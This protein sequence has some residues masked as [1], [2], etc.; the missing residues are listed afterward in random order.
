L[1]DIAD[2]DAAHAALRHW[3]GLQDA[4]A[5]SI[6]LSE[7]HCFRID[8]QD[9]NRFV[10]RLH[11]PGYQSR[12]TI[13]S[14]L[15]WL[16][17]IRAETPIPVPQ[18]VPAID[19]AAIVEA[20][21]DRFAALFAFE[22]GLEPRPEEALV[23][24]FAI[25]GRYAALAHR[26]AVAWPHPSGFV[27]PTWNAAAILDANGPWGDWRAAPGV[28]GDTAAALTA[29]DRRLRAR[30]AAYG[31]G[32][33][34]FG[35]IHADMRLANLLVDG[36]RVVL[37][38]FDDCGFGWFVYDLAA[39][40]SF[41]ETSPQVPALVAAWLAAYRAVRPLSDED[42]AMV[43]VMILFRRMALLAWIGS[44][45]ETGLAAAHRGRFAVDTVDLARRLGV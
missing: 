14:E 30:L 4:A 8:A 36:P 19:G 5:T 1:N 18:P 28:E 11:R 41:F 40:L 22:A 33:D 9:G 35:L 13:E 6:N 7:N 31:M 12:A 15:A 29:L 37:L 24:R 26:H 43:E 34:R 45:S 25:L 44:H 23:P 32:P 42:I 2:L 38:D 27:R 20:E 3:P 17:A 16:A 10:L 39:S 21:P